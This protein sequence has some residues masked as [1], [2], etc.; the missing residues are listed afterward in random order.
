MRIATLVLACMLFANSAFSQVVVVAEGEQFKPQRAERASS[1]GWRVVHQEESYATQTFGAMWVTHGGLLGAAADVTDAVATQ[2]VR[3]PEAGDYRVWSKYQSPPYYNFLHRIEVWQGGKMVFGHDY[4]AVDAERMWSFCGATTYNL[5]PKKQIWFSWGVDHDAAEAPTKPVRLSAGVAEIRLIAT[6]NAA[7]GGDRFIDF[8]LLTTNHENSCIGWEKHGQTKS[9]FTY[10]ALRATPIYVRFKNVSSKPAKAKLFTHFGHFTWHCAPKRGVI[11]EKAVA[12][13]A[14]SPWVNINEVVELLTDEGLQISLIDGT[15][16]GKA[17]QS[18]SALSIGSSKIPVQFARDAAGRNLLGELS[19][20]NA[21]TIHVPLD[22]VWNP[23]SKLQTSAEISSDLL[24]NA[25]KNWRTATPKKPQHIAFYGSFARGGS[26]YAIKLKDGLGYN[27]QLPKPYETLPVDGYHQHLRNEAQIRSFA[28]NLGDDRR[29]FRVCSFGDEISLGAIKFDDPKYIE[30]FRAWLKQKKLTKKQLGVDPSAAT[31][32]GNNRLKWY[33][34]L[35]SA[36]QRFAHYRNLTSVAKQA[37]GPQVLCGAN[38]SPHHDVMYYGNQLQWIDAFKHN[39]M[40]MFWAEDYIFFVPEL[41]QTISFMFARMNCATK[42][43]KQPIHFY[44]M[45][46]QPGQP[47]SYFR[48]NSLLSIGAGAKHIDHFWVAPQE[49]YS[50]N[51]VSWQY[52]Q[53]FQAIYETIHDTAAVESL[54]VNSKRRQARV[55][56]VT[57]KATALNE[58]HATVDINADKFLKMSHLTGKPKQNICRKDQQFLYF[59]LR[60]VQYQVELITEDDIL[61]GALKNFDVIYF[62]GEWIN[63]RAVPKLDAWVK[64]GG[65]LYASTG[66]GVKNQ[67]NEP[68]TSLLTLLGLKAADMRKNLY[69]V[70]PLLELPLADPIDTITM[71]VAAQAPTGASK[72]SRSVVTEKFDAFAMRQKLTIAND[73]TAILGRW[74]DGTAAVTVRNHGEGKAFAVGTA[75]GATWLKSGLAPVPWAR[76]G[77]VNLYNPTDFSAAATHLV[78]LGVNEAK[79]RPEAVCSNQFVESLLLDNDQGTL[80]TLVNWTNEESLANLQMS[81][82]LN[83]APSEVFSIVQN[84]KLPFEFADGR[85]TFSTNLQAADYVMLKK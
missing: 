56:I 21:A 58:D 78:R 53:T 28:E 24:Q 17:A 48:R 61:D 19:I 29:K 64:A 50:E 8:V 30:P 71:N 77:K 54:L 79:E 46:H 72:A 51:Y 41:P 40:S 55:A 20:A 36:E 67:Y 73:Q 7:P 25:K 45:P 59:A 5:P 44:V 52:P 22:I 63:D 32:T 62:A 57:G 76:G 74:S 49:N 3:I 27:T 13:G 80:L 84:K 75:V 34:T 66:L 12:P 35:F 16:E 70:R 6:R 82:R 83:K 31:L 26:D 68:E 81:V 2:T 42:Y 18:A 15:A 37:F 65:V 38:F 39:A 14:W 10:E 1:K 11:P 69:H 60:Q 23:A 9:P 43:H 47:A 85:V 33:A 4:G